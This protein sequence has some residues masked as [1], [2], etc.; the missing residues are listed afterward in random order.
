MSGLLI[1]MEFSNATAVCHSQLNGHGPTIT[2]FGKPPD[3]QLF[4]GLRIVDEELNARRPEIRGP[5]AKFVR[6][7]TLLLATKVAQWLRCTQR[8]WP[9]Q[10]DE[11]VSRV[12]ARAARH[13]LNELP[14]VGDAIAYERGRMDC[15]T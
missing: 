15:A 5:H 14:A 6:R 4:A 11:V 10:D 12:A 9:A 3:P 2:S 1:L 13:V 8:H 7:S